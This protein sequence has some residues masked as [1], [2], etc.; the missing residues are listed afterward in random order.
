MFHCH[1]LLHYLGVGV[2]VRVNT[3]V[4]V[5]I[6]VRV[7]FVTRYAA[8]HM[9]APSLSLKHSNLPEAAIPSGYG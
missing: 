1:V 7:P 3:R 5:N 8:T 9:I 6:R 4:W 2:S